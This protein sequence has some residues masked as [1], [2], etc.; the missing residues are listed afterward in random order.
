M[1]A[2]PRELFQGSEA[3]PELYQIEKQRTRLRVREQRMEE[4][5]K[6]NVFFQYWIMGEDKEDERQLQNESTYN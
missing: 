1:K 3:A 6:K 2:A 5:E 4:K